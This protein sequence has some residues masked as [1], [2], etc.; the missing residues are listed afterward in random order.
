MIRTIEVE[1]DESGRMHPT[2]PT[3][4]L[5]NGRALVTWQ[6]D[7]DIDCMLMSEASLAVD[8]LKPEEDE[9]WAYMQ[10]AK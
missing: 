3:A 7:P 10:P 8:W 4:E 6:T 1:I 5:P 2:E 9:A